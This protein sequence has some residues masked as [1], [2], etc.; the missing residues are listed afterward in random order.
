MSELTQYPVRRIEEVWPALPLEAWRPTYQ[1][2]HMWTQIVGKVRLALSPMVNHWWH[3]PLYVTARGLSTGPMPY[4]E[5]DLEIHFDFIDHN[6]LILASDGQRKVIPLIPRSVADFYGELMAGLKA[7]EMPVHIWTTPVEIPEPIPFERD[8]AH[9][10]YDPQYVT[11]LWQIL[12]QTEQIFQEFRGRFLGKCS[13]VHFFWGSFDLA[14][15]R[16]SGRRAPEKPGADRITR[17]AYSHEV[18][19]HGFWPGGAWFGME[20][21]SPVYYSYT[22]PEPPGLREEPVRP[23]QAFYHPQLSEFVLMYDDLRHA[24]SP[25]Q[26]LLE[27]LQSTYEAGARRAA[28]DRASLDREPALQPAG[29]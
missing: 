25:R 24:D 12:V 11:R 20:V 28:W 17:E 8:H 7:M 6:L 13:P 23:S 1:T 5:R 22:V 14:V 2:L 21:N 4:G 10:A 16:F 15:T 9:A 27:F 19:S 18:I 29:T 26:A 3:V